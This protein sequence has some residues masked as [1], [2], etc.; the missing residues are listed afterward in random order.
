MN[1]RTFIKCSFESK[2]QNS[3]DVGASLVAQWSRI[4]VPMQETSVQ[5][6]IWED[7]IFHGA[8]KPMCHSH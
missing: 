2:T 8:T 1:P 3:T 7:P 6:L 4:H 5:P